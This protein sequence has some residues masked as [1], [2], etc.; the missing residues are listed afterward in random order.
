[1]A[2]FDTTQIVSY[3]LFLTEERRAPSNTVSSYVRDVAGFADYL[4]SVGRAGFEGVTEEDF[5]LFLSQLEENGRSPATISRCVVSVKA[6]YNYLAGEGRVQDN[7]VAGV[8]AAAAKKKPP[9]IL[10]SS[11]IDRLL[12]QP[13]SSDPKGCRDKAMLETLYA[14]GIRVSELVALNESDVNLETALITCRNGKERVIPIYAEAIRAIGLYLSAARPK[15]AK[16]GECALFVN[17]TGK[18]M[19]RQG[20]W[21]LLKGYTAKAQI[22]EDMTPQ[23]LRHSFA[24]HLLENGADLRSLQELLGHADISS[25]QV[26][27]RAV[28]NQLKDVYTKAHPRAK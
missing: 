11:E 28:K 4:C 22:T 17:T 6:F 5:K 12:E 13:D 3:K 18:R 27:A 23:I 26:Y 21:K 24:A 8:S 20:F 9:R 2:V 19:S 25:T 1:M 14:T 10:M 7:P 16:P 15:F